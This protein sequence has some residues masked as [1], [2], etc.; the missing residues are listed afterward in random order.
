[1]KTIWAK[2]KELKSK[3]GEDLARYGIFIACG[4]LVLMII[5]VFWRF[6]Q[7]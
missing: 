6:G 4:S 5:M 7:Y 1:M 2:L 3:D